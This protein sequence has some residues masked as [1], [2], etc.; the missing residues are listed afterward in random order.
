MSRLPLS[1]E[2]AAGSTYYRITSRQYLTSSITQNRQVFSG[3]GAI[4]N[5]VG[6]RYNYPGARTVYLTDALETCLAERMFYFHR[7]TVRL[8]DVSTTWN[9]I[10]AFHKTFILWA[11]TFKRQVANLFDLMKTPNFGRFGIY[12]SLLTNPTQDYQHL[13]QKRAE[14]ETA[15]YNGLVAPSARST[16]GGAIVVLFQDQS[17]NVQLMNHY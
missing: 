14:I 1:T 5:S 12:P 2:L 3:Q 13:K 4:N 8:L 10:P 15:H 9:N 17:N 6:A 16:K 7:E 11:I